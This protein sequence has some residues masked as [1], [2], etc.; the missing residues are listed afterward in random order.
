MHTLDTEEPLY[1]PS[2]AAQARLPTSVDTLFQEWNVAANQVRLTLDAPPSAMITTTG[3]S[4]SPAEHLASELLQ[5]GRIS[6]ADMDK[7][8]GMLPEKSST[9][10]KDRI[11]AQLPRQKC[12]STGAFTFAHSTGIQNNT[13]LSTGDAT[14][15]VHHQGYESGG[16]FRL[17]DATKEHPG[18]AA[19]RRRQ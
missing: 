17:D 6:F 11:S 1:S 8:L 13:A 4:D 7:L 19:S 18:T 5:L 3:P 16:V 9:K 2:L 14:A 10:Q 12:F 15:H